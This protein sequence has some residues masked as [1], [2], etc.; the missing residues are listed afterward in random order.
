M[1]CAAMTRRFGP[2]VVITAAAVM[3]AVVALDVPVERLLLVGAFLLC[4]LMMLGMHGAGHGGG[5]TGGDP[6]ANGAGPAG[7]DG[8]PHRH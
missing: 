7:S 5:S 6:G 3:L 8:S 1:R 4:P 2:L